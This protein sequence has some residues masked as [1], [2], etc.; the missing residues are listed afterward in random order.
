MSMLKVQDY[1]RNLGWQKV[2]EGAYARARDSITTLNGVE[3]EPLQKLNLRRYARTFDVNAMPVCVCEVAPLDRRDLHGNLYRGMP[4]Y[5]TTDKV[6][7]H[8]ADGRGLL[9]EDN[10]QVTHRHRRLLDLDS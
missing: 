1:L 10:A 3:I 5:T 6:S 7:L 4:F 2:P 9:S 8:Y